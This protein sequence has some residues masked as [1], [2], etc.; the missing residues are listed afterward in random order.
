MKYEQTDDITTLKPPQ[1]RVRLQRQKNTRPIDAHKSNGRVVPRH[2][3]LTPVLFPCV[4]RDPFFLQRKVHPDLV[5]DIL[6]MAGDSVT[7][8]EIVN[9]S[10]AAAAPASPTCHSAAEDVVDLIAA[11][12]TPV[13]RVSRQAGFSRHMTSAK[14]TTFIPMEVRSSPASAY[15]GPRGD[16]TNSGV[17]AAPHKLNVLPQVTE[18]DGTAVEDKSAMTLSRDAV[19]IT[20][21]AS[22]TVVEL[23]TTPLMK[24]EDRVRALDAALCYPMSRQYVGNCEIF[25]VARSNGCLTRR[26]VSLHRLVQIIRLSIFSCFCF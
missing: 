9:Q 24:V 21:P 26:T 11:V 8:S 23:P 3:V 22:P 10:A 18:D 12:G 13:G 6:Q 14:A 4:S 16:L 2:S 25:L 19:D 15:E 7:M 20:R 17:K 1:I 5:S